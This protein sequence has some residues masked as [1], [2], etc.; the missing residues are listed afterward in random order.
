MKELKL[1]LK[2]KIRRL[3]LF[4]RKGI[5]GALTG[6]YRTVFRGKGLEFSDFRMYTPQDDAGRIDW[7]TSLR[8]QQLLIKDYEEERNINVIFLVDVSSTMSFA[9]VDKLKNEYAAEIVASL[10]FA[11]LQVGDNAGLIM[12]SDKVNFYILPSGGDRQY[13]MMLRAI[14]NPEYYEGKKNF[15]KSIDF[16]MNFI[17]ERAVVI[18][19]SDF[20][21]FEKDWPKALTTAM[22]KFEIIGLMVRDPR[23]N[24]MPTGTG[25]VV[26]SDPLS[27]ARKTIDPDYIKENYEKITKAQKQEVFDAF[28][29]IGSDV[30]ELTTDKP[31]MH[32]ILKLLKKR[33]RR[34]R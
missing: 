13:F 19:I 1:D 34:M 10:S 8:A 14:S 21:G 3:E 11:L 31:F 33:E 17:K 23:D 4:T 5:T 7:K 26:L 12:F 30:L 24:T 2:P 16:L 9:S 18:I 28:A 27:S 32:P 25:N 15:T 20:I 6:A 29:L 22:G